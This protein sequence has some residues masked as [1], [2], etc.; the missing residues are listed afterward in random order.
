[1]NDSEPNSLLMDNYMIDFSKE[2]IDIAN[3]DKI[4]NDF[5]SGKDLEKNKLE[6]KR[7][8]EIEENEK[9]KEKQINSEKENNEEKKEENNYKDGEKNERLLIINKSE[10]STELKKLYVIYFLSGLI[11][12]SLILFFIIFDFFAKIQKGTIECTYFSPG[13]EINILNPNYNYEK[14][15]LQIFIND[16]EINKNEKY[17]SN[18]TDSFNVTIKLFS[19]NIDLSDMFTSQNVKTVIMKS[20]NSIKI[21]N[22]RNVF[23][24]CTFLE[25]FEIDGF[26]S[27]QVKSMSKLF[28]NTK[29]LKKINIS[30]LETFSLE[31][32][33][34]MFAYTNLQEINLTKF[35]L[36]K[37]LKSKDIFKDIKSSKVI[38]NKKYENQKENLTEIYPNINFEFQN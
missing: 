12:I 30:T 7:K 27:S 3:K 38:L 32:M 31:D 24:N 11:V 18:G 19:D 34:Y 8:Q 1:M 10:E 9:D 26:N 15:I 2:D 21:K 33:D 14:D 35:D 6:E 17:K 25:N 28:Y 22:M 29:N 37:I 20:Q 13:N 4:I 16:K 36:D 23:E 5:K